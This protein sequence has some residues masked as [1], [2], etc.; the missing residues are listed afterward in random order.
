MTTLDQLRA[1]AL[2]GATRLDLQADLKE[3]PPEVYGLADTLEVLN[4]NGN[5]LKHLPADLPRL[6]RLKVLFCSNN[7]FTEL[8]EVLGQCPALEM[9]GF[10]ACAIR[11]IPAASLP[12]ALRWLILTDNHIKTLPEV[13]DG[14]PRLQ[15]LMLAGNCLTGLP[16]SLAHCGA[17]ELIRIACNDLIELPSW[18]LRL[19]RLAWLAFAGNPGFAEHQRRGRPA[20]AWTTFRV[21]RPL[22]EGASGI[23]YEA[24]SATNEAVALKCYRAGRTSDG[25]PT[26]EIAASLQAGQH[27]NLIAAHAELTGH[28]EGLPGLVMER[29][30][31][32]YRNLAAPPSLETCT[33]DCYPGDTWFTLEQASTLLSG[34]ASAAAHLHR[35]GISHG[36]LYA[37]NVLVDSSGHGLLGDFGAASRY[38]RADQDQA[39]A[40]EAIEARALGIMLEEISLRC[41][42]PAE[43]WAGLAR[44]CQ[45]P[46]TL[47]RP[48]LEEVRARLL[49]D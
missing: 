22:G 32:G 42:Q 48:S 49:S 16:A 18:L 46:D 38:T 47:A 31:T 1:G 21:G 6:K 5:Q 20:M 15:K 36:D 41:A 28:P 14:L 25:T 45:Q 40:L 8:P 17:L 27:P 35:R 34:I 43:H 12:P 13:F 2:A 37:H 24:W 29:I 9:I 44:A 11:Q 30:G 23:V 19:P 4:L 39:R 26:D 10:K 3:V 33:R 7:P